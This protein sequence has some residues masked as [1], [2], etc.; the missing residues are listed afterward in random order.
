MHSIH[1]LAP[2]LRK[3][4]IGVVVVHPGLIPTGLYSHNPLGIGKTFACLGATP[5]LRTILHFVMLTEEQGAWA[6]LVACLQEHPTGSYLAYGHSWKP[7]A[8]VR[9]TDTAA[10][11]VNWTKE[12]LDMT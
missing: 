10:K 5:I 6:V 11:L 12:R 9:R 8:L 4:G 1:T 7:S 2:Q 3:L